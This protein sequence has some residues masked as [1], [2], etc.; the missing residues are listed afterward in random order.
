[1]TVFN[2]RNALVG[3]VTLKAASRALDRRRRSRRER[4]GRGLKLA[5]FAALALVSLGILAGVAAAFARRRRG[6]EQRRL[7]GYAVGEDAEGAAAADAEAAPT[8]PI[9][10][11]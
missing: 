7:E 3:F 9:A 1:M 5:L 4:V 8:E 11:T 2:R 10:A 6:V